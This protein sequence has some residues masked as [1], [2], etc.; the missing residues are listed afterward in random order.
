MIAS[1][2]WLPTMLSKFA[3]VGKTADVLPQTA[4][5]TTTSAKRATSP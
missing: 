4:K 2:D 5:N 3:D 1:T